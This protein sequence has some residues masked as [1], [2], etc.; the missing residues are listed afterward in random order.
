[1]SARAAVCWQGWQV[2]RVIFLTR[3]A[4]WMAVPIRV[5]PK[6]GRE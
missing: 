5:I 2:V 1:L 4:P 3:Y 6:Q